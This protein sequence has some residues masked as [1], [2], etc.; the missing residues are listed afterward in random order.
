M[1]INYLSQ[2][3]RLKILRI[4]NTTTYFRHD[5]LLDTTYFRHDIK[6]TGHRIL[7]SQYELY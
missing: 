6:L 2:Y 5:I 4:S 1:F 3:E 7:T